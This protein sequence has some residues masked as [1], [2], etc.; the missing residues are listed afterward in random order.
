MS[1]R[2]PPQTETAAGLLDASWQGARPEFSHR[3]SW[4][5]FS[6]SHPSF[7]KYERMHKHFVGPKTAVDLIRIHDDLVAVP[8]DDEY[9]TTAGWAM[10]EAA[11]VAKDRPVGE[12]LG[13]LEE[14]AEAWAAALA[15]RREENAG[16]GITEDYLDAEMGRLQLPGAFLPIME[17]M[18]QGDVTKQARMTSYDQLLTLAAQNAIGLVEARR[19]GETGGLFIGL[20]HELNAMLSVNRLLSPTLI[21]VPAPARADS[22]IYH[23]KQTHDV[24][25]WHLHWGDVRDVTTLEAKARPRGK[26]YRRYDAAIVNGRI[27]LYTKNAKSPVDTVLLFLKEEKSELSDEEKVELENMTDTI[28]HLARHQLSED[29]SVPL[30]CRDVNRCEKVPLHRSIPAAVRALGGLAAAS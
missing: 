11:L 24:E 3:S 9:L 19:R 14:A 21:A 20:G 7:Q 30:H 28:V 27:H 25:L 18:I 13:Y 17:G 4:G 10:A 2:F 1:R 6:S 29:P 16:Y 15:H 8:P 23:P 5:R 22:G 26:H 12:R